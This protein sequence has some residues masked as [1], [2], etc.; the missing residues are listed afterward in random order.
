MYLQNLNGSGMG[1]QI[2]VMKEADATSANFDW[3]DGEG[4]QMP[5]LVKNDGPDE[6]ELEVRMWDGDS[7]VRTVFA[8]GWNPELIR[9]IKADAGLLSA[10][11]K[12]G[13]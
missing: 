10:D 4:Q 12:A 8:C 7:F 5:F 3:K 2:S 6:I 9:E 11:I 1:L 13:R